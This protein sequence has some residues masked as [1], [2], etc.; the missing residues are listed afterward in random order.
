MKITEV[1]TVFL[2]KGSRILIVKRSQKV[3]TF[4]GSWS[5]ISGYLEAEPLE[6]AYIEVREETG[7]TG[8][9]ILHI[10]IGNYL[11]I[12][13]PQ[14]NNLVWR[15]HPFRFEIKPDSK[16]KLDWENLE[17]K[18]IF[19]DQINDFETVPG[20]KE[21]WENAEDGKEIT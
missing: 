1:V 10:F 14:K 11:D 5:G 13:H 19:P 17:K 6:Q 4:R 2:S 15:V 18:W 3:K 9:D 20:L 8:Q 21:A 12:K 16:I 7:I